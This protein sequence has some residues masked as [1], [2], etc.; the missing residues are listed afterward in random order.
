MAIF[1][2]TNL[3]FPTGLNITQS[4]LRTY[5]NTRPHASPHYNYTPC[6]TP[7]PLQVPL[8]EQL[9]DSVFTVPIAE[10]VAGLGDGIGVPVA[11]GT[12]VPK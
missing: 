7:H 2:A 5:S 9:A 1:L 12:E 8:E 4:Q 6:C 3:C 10:A 11:L